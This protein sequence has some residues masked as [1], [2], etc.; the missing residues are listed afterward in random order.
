[1]ALAQRGDGVEQAAAMADGRDTQVAQV[2][3]REPA[4]NLPIGG[5]RFAQ[6]RA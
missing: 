4:Q 2:L 6:R 5:G 3:S 1:L